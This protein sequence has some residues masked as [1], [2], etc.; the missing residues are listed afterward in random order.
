MHEALLR[1]SNSIVTADDFA[2]FEFAERTKLRGYLVCVGCGADAYFVR[3]AR[4]GRRACFGSSPHRPDCELA[5]LLTEDGGSA[6]L[7]ET[8]LLKGRMWVLSTWLASLSANDEDLR[9][10]GAYGNPHAPLRRSSWRS[11]D[12][13]ARGYDVYWM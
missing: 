9:V 3:E 13:Y 4:N 1:S 11:N 7:D 10:A 6:K 8:G 2:A 12:Q 5:S